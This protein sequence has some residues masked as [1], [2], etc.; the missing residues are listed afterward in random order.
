[1]KFPRRSLLAIVAVVAVVSACGDDDTSAT[2]GTPGPGGDR[3]VTLLTHDAFAISESVFEVF[4]AETGIRVQVRTGAD[5]GSVLAQVI[6]TKDDPVADVV[7]G[8]DNTFLARALSEDLF[9]PYASSRLA[10]VDPQFVL[11]P[12]HRVTPIDYGDVCVNYWTDALDGPPPSSIDDLTDPVYASEWVT[13]NPETSSPGLALL[14]ATIAR[15]GEDG[16]EDWWASAADAGV[17][18]T[19]G[20]TEAYYGEFV[21]GGGDRAV[22]TSYATS[23]VAE[24]VFAETPV[25]EAPTGVITDGCFRQIE[26]AGI[27][28]GTDRSAEARELVDFMLSDTFQSDIPLSMFVYPV[29]GDVTLPEEFVEYGVTVTEPLS[30][31]PERIGE[32]R[33]EWT[34][35][36][37]EIVLR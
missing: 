32:M 37:V 4:E 13:Q 14:L 35:R 21:A 36:W 17:T 34:R 9:E 33:D 28:S 27:L 7:F 20:W 30:L 1:M 3:T 16:W 31:D 24:V 6:L 12:E 2:D 11:D 23:P 26:F 10:S 29:V 22:V 19:A 18:V 8:V 5:A 15:Y 25:T